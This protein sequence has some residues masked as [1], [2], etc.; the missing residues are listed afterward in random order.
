MN[1]TE[2]SDVTGAT[3]TYLMNGMAPGANWTGSFGPGEA[4]AAALRQHLG[5]VD[6][7][8]QDP[9]PADDGHPGE[10]PAREARRDGRDPNRRR[11]ALRRD[12]GDRRGPSV[13]DLRRSRGPERLRPGNVGAAGRDGGRRT[14]APREAPSHDGRHGHDARGGRG[15]GR[16]GWN[17]GHGGHARNAGDGAGAG[18]GRDAG[19]AGLRTARGCARRASDAHGRRDAGRASARNCAGADDAPTGRPRTRKRRRRH[20]RPRADSTSPVW[21]S[22]TTAGA[23]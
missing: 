18:D 22:V 5:R 8:R 23:C 11:G 6:L 21:G 12:R 3:Y 9:R 2:I 4:G 19:A 13:H 14:R 16:H 7:R 10:R 15:D 1:P 17:A 20:E